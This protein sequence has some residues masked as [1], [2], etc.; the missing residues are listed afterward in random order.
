MQQ[1]SVACAEMLLGLRVNVDELTRTVDEPEESIVAVLRQR[2]SVTEFLGESKK[3][4]SSRCGAGER[5]MLGSR[6]DSLTLRGSPASSWRQRK[7]VFVMVLGG[8]LRRYL[9]QLFFNVRLI[10]KS[11]GESRQKSRLGFITT[12]P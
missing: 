3:V 7:G 2:A 9:P 12:T 4:S 8:R 5:R 1:P 10:Y 11:I 6:R